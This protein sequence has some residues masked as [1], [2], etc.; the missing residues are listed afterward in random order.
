MKYIILF[1][2]HSSVLAIGFVL[3][4]YLLPIL[5]AQKS[6]DINEIEKL[7]SNVI[8]QTEFKK[9]QKVMYS[10]YSATALVD[11]KAVVED[12]LSIA[13]AKKAALVVLAQDDVM[14]YYDVK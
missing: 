7:S 12:E 11:A 14:A 9:G 5:T 8:Y 3:G 1:F 10:Q 2:S 4:I 6:A 13:D